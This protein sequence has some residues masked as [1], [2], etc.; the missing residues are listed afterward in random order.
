MYQKILVP[1]DGSAHSHYTLSE[2]VK[3]AGYFGPG[4]SLTVVHVCSYV[5]FSEIAMETD[6]NKLLEEEGQSVL[7]GVEPF[8]TDAPFVHRSIFLEGDPAEVI[9]RTATQEG[10][11]LVIIGTRGRGLFS[12]LLLGSVS[13]KVLQ[14]APCPVLVIR[15]PDIV[16][17]K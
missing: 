14:H 15:K 10:I 13:H 16:V 7:E 4:V 3:L 6:L 2:A 1:I 9:C 12:E 11:D 17:Q 8:L 5:A